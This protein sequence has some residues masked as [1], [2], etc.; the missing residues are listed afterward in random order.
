M[1]VG[2]EQFQSMICVWMAYAT[3]WARGS[4]AFFLIQS[5]VYIEPAS[6][7]LSPLPEE[8]SLA[9]ASHLSVEE[10]TFLADK[11]LC[12]ALEDQ[13]HSYH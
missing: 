8:Y 11:G 1:A 2:T 10:G 7:R 12:L 5:M 6:L 13:Y 3:P 4:L 9:Q